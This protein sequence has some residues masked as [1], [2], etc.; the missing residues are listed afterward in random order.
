YKRNYIE[1]LFLSSAIFGSPDVTMEALI[2]VARSLRQEHRFGGYIHLKVIP[3]ATPE[4]LREAGR[5][6][7]RLSANVELPTQRDLDALAPEKTMVEIEE[8]MG[9]IRKG[10]DEAKLDRRAPKFAPAGQTTQMVVGA[11]SAPDSEILATASSLYKSQGLRRI[12]YS[13][14]SPFPK[15]DFRL[16]VEAPPLV[17]EHRLYQADWLMRFYGFEASEL[18]TDSQ[19]N[20]ELDRDPKLSWALRN[21]AFFPIDVNRATREALLRIPGVG[22][23]NVKAILSA[24]R[25]RKLSLDDL[26]KLRVVIRRARPFLI[27]ADHSPAV[28]IL[29][30]TSLAASLPSTQMTLFGALP[31]VLSGEL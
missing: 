15:S 13:A 22:Y 2:R 14:F 29:D 7:D 18:T 20:Q 30:S 27:T 23:R 16:P 24:R 1:G 26:T 28:R 9:E 10:V 25:H 19:Q 3:G 6:A 12:Y 11:T 4:L 8:T 5:W 31:S 17:R 21:R